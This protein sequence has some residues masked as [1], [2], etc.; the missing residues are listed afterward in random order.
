MS[1]TVKE[2]V[3]E[4]V[5]ELEMFDDWTERYGYIIDLGKEL[6]NLGEEYHTDEYLLPGCQSRLWLRTEYKDGKMYIY[7]DSDSL[8]VKG[9]VA[10]LIRVYSDA[11]PEEITAT[12]PDFLKQLG[13]DA[14]LSPSRA[15]GLHSMIDRILAAAAHYEKK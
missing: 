3:S 13:F 7:A 9:L 5:D 4:V 8:I 11:G 12:P 15:N 14:S 6:D 10:L 1:E 2:R